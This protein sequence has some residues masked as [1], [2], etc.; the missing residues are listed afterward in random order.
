MWRSDKRTSLAPLEIK[1]RGSEQY[2]VKLERNGTVA[3]MMLV[4]ANSIA[5][6]RM[7]LGTYTLKYA[8]GTGEYWCGETARVPFGRQTAYHRAGDTFSFVKQTDVYFGHVVELY[9][10][11]DVTSAPAACHRKHGEPDAR[12][13]RGRFCM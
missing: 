2:L 3:A 4:R 11:R 8:T 1:V 12:R 6:M 10:R 9:L 13:S 7:P 5:K